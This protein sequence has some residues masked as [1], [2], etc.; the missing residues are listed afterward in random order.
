MQIILTSD[1]T[2]TIFDEARNEIY[3]SRAGAAAESEHVFINAGFVPK[4]AQKSEINILEVGF[5][6]GLNL[7]LSA[8]AHQK[9]FSSKKVS[10]TGIENFPLRADIIKDLNF[11]NL[12]ENGKLV[13]TF[14]QIHEAAWGEEFN[15]HKNF[16]AKKKCV[17]L[18]DFQDEGVFDLVFFDAFSPEKQPE[19]WELPLFEKIYA[20][21]AEGGFLVTYCAKGMVKRTLRAAG[22]RV[23]TL[24]GPPRKREMIRAVKDE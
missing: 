4:I 20:M 13:L 2:H 1:G 15:L 10:Y 11:G 5:D 16:S 24:P 18:Q 12:I 21:T 14:E 9:Y 23:E 17:S 7:F 3:H 19:M 22:F 8:V 6:T